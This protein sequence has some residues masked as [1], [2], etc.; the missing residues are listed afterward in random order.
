LILPFNADT[1][2]VL[3]E[4]RLDA[5][6]V[7]VKKI[8]FADQR[9]GSKF[10]YAGRDQYIVNNSD[11]LLPIAIR[12]AGRLQQHLVKVGSESRIDRTFAVDYSPVAHHA[13]TPVDTDRLSTAMQEWDGDYLIHWTRA[14][15]GPWPGETAAQFYQDLSASSNSY[16]RSARDSLQRIIR[17]QTIRA[18]SWRIGGDV[19]VVAFSGLAPVAALPLMRWRARWARWSFEPYGIAI[20]KDAALALG[21]RAVRYVSELEWKEL[22][23]EEKPFCHRKGER[24]D[25][26]SAEDEWRIRGDVDLSSIP[27]DA[28]RVIVRRADELT[29]ITSTTEYER[30]HFEDRQP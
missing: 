23:L 28:V 7:T 21:A 12:P 25:V 1:H 20:R 9:T 5:S 27:R 24:E 4:F 19:P 26:W 16:C 2:H 30:V 22:A 13:T 29:A 10:W 18:S 3:N 17:E 8:V 6:S 14:R 11:V 15:H